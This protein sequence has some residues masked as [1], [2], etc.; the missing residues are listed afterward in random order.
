MRKPFIMLL[1]LVLL[2]MV[3]D[4]SP[5]I[6]QAQEGVGPTTEPTVIRSDEQGIR[7]SWNLPAY[8]LDEIDVNGTP[9]S[10]LTVLGLRLSDTPGHPQVPVVGR[11]IGLP[12]T[13][14]A[15]VHIIQLEQETVSLPF[16]P[17]PVPVPQP[18]HLSQI[19]QVNPITGAPTEIVPDPGTYSENS[20]SPPTIAQL[21]QP[22]KIREQRIVQ[23]IL[24]PVQVNPVSREATVVRYLEL[25]IIFEEAA[26]PPDSTA[27]RRSETDPFAQILRPNLL[28][29]QALDW[30][31]ASPKATRSNSLRPA[32]TPDIAAK[33]FK[34]YLKEPGLYALTYAD[35]QAAGFPVNSLDPRTF[36]MEH[37]Y[38]RTEIAI[39]VE[40]ETDGVFNTNDRIL[41]YGD[42]DF[43]RYTR[44]DVYFLSYGGAGGSRVQSRSGSPAGLPAGTVWR[45]TQAEKNKVPETQLRDHN[46]TPWFWGALLR[47]SSGSGTPTVINGEYTIQ[48]KKPLTSG[49]PAQ[50]KVWLHG[51]TFQYFVNP[52]HRTSVS[53]E[54]TYLGDLVWDG[55]TAVEKTFS[56]ASQRLK[57]GDNKIFLTLPGTDATSEKTFVDA[58]ELTYPT[59]QADAGQLFF[60]GDPGKRAYTIGGWA[61][62]GLKVYD[63]SIP[64][65][66]KQVV[67]Y[68][69]NGHTLTLG[70]I[71]DS[72]AQYLVV[73]N[74][75]LK[76]PDFILSLTTYANPPSGADYIIISHPDFLGAIAPLAAH[77]QADGLRVATFNVAAIYDNFGPGHLD[78]EAIRTF[79]KYAYENDSWPG[80]KPQ[81]VLLVGDGDY[82]FKNYL[83]HNPEIPT[84]L[85]PYLAAGVDPSLGETASDNRLVSVSGQDNKPDMMI[86]R[87]P[88]NSAAETTTVVNKIINYEKNPAPG[89]W[90]GRH[91][92]VT[93]KPEPDAGGDFSKHADDAYSMLQPPNVG[94]RF[95]V[96]ETPQHPSYEYSNVEK[97]RTNFYNQFNNGAGIISFHG[98]SFWHAWGSE[99]SNPEPIL[100]WNRDPAHNDISALHN[101]QRLPLILQMTCLTGFFH[102]PEYPTMDEELLRHPNGGAIAVFGSSGLGVATGHDILQ[103]TFYTELL[104]KRQT[105]LGTLIETSKI[106]VYETSLHRD[107]ID[108]FHLF[109][110]PALKLNIPTIP[111]ENHIYL[112]LTFKR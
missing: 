96:N 41:F 51:W 74:N 107:L 43:S 111:F 23:L 58:F 33:T 72:Q 5:A 9:Y 88:V 83:N 19:D 11:L 79:L 108:T 47:F 75:E 7:L 102:H 95:Y 93:G 42:P 97:L 61:N 18:V 65:L 27:K 56:V 101:G 22:E 6:L 10:K 25:E 50:L 90:N 59:N 63:I 87:L 16:A 15:T 91:L 106:A 84:Y 73:R 21:S 32:T 71:D 44:Y 34:I 70:D 69:Y 8:Q 54:G 45:T 2:L 94:Q 105:N 17:L 24:N 14:G 57:E 110:D 67:N 55:Q 60:R 81:Y 64:A 77:R 12:P 40:G 78:A 99:R 85:P 92:F 29:P 20:F 46:D 82:D 112:P 100:G 103:R 13:G 49:P 89:F 30:V 38:P 37:G 104:K 48:I 53:F 62:A 4:N 3:N 35:L 52:D 31:A 39:T 26:P 76:T 1:A 28:N 98:H 86:G 80:P 68:S 66:P 109:G 36:K